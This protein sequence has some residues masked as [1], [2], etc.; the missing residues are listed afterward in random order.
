MR[1]LL[2]PL[3]G[4]ALAEQILPYVQLL[5]S[6]WGGDVRLLHA[7]GAAERAALQDDG[8]A[9][10]E[11]DPAQTP[12]VCAQC[13]MVSICHHAGCHVSIQATE[14][15][16]QNIPAIADVQ[17][18]AAAKIIDAA[19]HS[20]DT[21]IAMTTHADGGLRRW[22]RGS[23]A[24]QLLHT[25]SAPL[26]LVREAPFPPREPALKRILTPLDGSAL[27]RRA[28]PLAIELAARAD[29]EL[30]LLQIVAPS[31]EEYLWS[32]PA[33][34]MIRQQMHE[35]AMQT[36]DEIAAGLPRRP[37]MITTATAIGPPAATIVEEASRRRADLIV[38]AT[39]VDSGLRRWA[40]GSVADQLLQLSNTPLLLVR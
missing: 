36:F 7:I 8:A 24:D 12:P 39:H 9:R 37:V 32:G 11:V 3:D 17:P 21:L 22:A 2:V 38:M 20:S 4:S 23:V 10:S 33:A 1:T 14:L 29:A 18:G 26:L 15:R 34:A 19:A 27:A 25:T 30:M 35:Q 6:I 13:M 28:L 40:R 16:K 31:I 5:A